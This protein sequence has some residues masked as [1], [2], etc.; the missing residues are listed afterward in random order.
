VG[1]A[2]RTTPRQAS[3]RSYHVPV[4]PEGSKPRREYG[5][6]G[7]G[8]PHYTHRGV[9]LLPCVQKIFGRKGRKFL[10]GI[11]GPPWLEVP[12][13]R[14]YRPGKGHRVALSHNPAS[15][16]LPLVSGF[17]PVVDLIPK[18]T[19][20]A[21]CPHSCVQGNLEPGLGLRGVVCFPGQLRQV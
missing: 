8:Y 3:E 21:L 13:T 1:G 15:S 12:P 18:V 20:V 5:H 2:A 10:E 11:V 19:L 4:S 17:G 16:P 14:P 9:W 6:Q 7:N